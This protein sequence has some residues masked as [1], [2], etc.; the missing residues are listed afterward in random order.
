MILRLLRNPLET[1][2]RAARNE[3]VR[4]DFHDDLSFGFSVTLAGYGYPYV[5]VTGHG[6]GPGQRP[7]RL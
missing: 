1:I 7:V 2:L 5:Q 6:V 4:P 3:K